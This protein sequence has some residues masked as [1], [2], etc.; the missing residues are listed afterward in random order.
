MTPV[1]GSAGT[2]SCCAGTTRCWR[3]SAPWTRPRWFPARIRGRERV[4]GEEGRQF[5]HRD[6]RVR[7]TR[8]RPR[9]DR[10]PSKPSPLSSSLP[11][12]LDVSEERVYLLD[13]E[14]RPG[15]Q[16]FTRQSAVP[17]WARE[18]ARRCE[19][20]CLSPHRRPV[21]SKQSQ[22]R[23][24]T[25]RADTSRNAPRRNT[26]S[27]PHRVMAAG[28]AGG[29]LRRDAPGTGGVGGLSAGDKRTNCP[30]INTMGVMMM[31]SLGRRP[32]VLGLVAVALAA[33]GCGSNRP[34]G[35]TGTS[36]SAQAS[37]PATSTAS[38][39]RS[40][41]QTIMVSGRSTTLKLDPGT[42]Q[43]LKAAGVQISPVS[44]ATA[45]PS[46]G[47]NFPITGGTLTQAGLQG[48][49]NHSGGL[50]FTHAGKTVT[51]T[52]FVLNTTQ[53]TLSATVNGKQVPLLVVDLSKMVRT[54]RGRLIVASGI[55]STLTRS[56]VV[57]LD[58]RLR[59]TVFT[60]TL[61]IGT[62][63]AYVTGNAA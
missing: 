59:V 57:L 21:G 40:A 10:V 30:S 24:P 61:P 12:A 1:V 35:P 11:A 45:A 18:A 52:N 38:P 32:L 63:T 55:T 3:R 54:T 44:P 34:S 37:R 50:T 33:A 4:V 39:S 19:W 46:G 51:A 47:I 14:E 62:L 43:A 13:K 6:V 23:Y 49:I 27:H 9:G 5:C 29:T 25:W 22:C 41:A 7:A 15:T 20:G 58:A 31:A 26:V 36:P 8:R 56:A 2:R 17:G 28:A 16:T 53:R 48:S 42:A 60:R